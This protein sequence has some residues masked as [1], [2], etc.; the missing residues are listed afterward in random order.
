LI[1]GIG[2]WLLGSVSWPT[3]LVAADWFVARHL[4]WQL[5]RCAHPG[6]D[7]TPLLAAM[8]VLLGIRMLRL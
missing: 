4:H 1:A 3:A 2:H 5:F 8:L 7:P 6:E